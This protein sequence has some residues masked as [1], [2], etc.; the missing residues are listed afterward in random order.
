MEAVIG[1][2]EDVSANDAMC[3]MQG[4]SV[5]SRQ[6]AATAALLQLARRIR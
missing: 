2:M 6:L 5:R 3:E 4:E 1:C